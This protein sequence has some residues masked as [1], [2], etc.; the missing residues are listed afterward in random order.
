VNGSPTIT[1]PGY[2]QVNNPLFLIDACF[3]TT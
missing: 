3:D 1:G 2:V